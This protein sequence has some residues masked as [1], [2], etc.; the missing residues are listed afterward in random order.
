MNSVHSFSS[1]PAGAGVPPSVARIS[2]TASVRSSS[3]MSRS[4]PATP[5]AVSTSPPSSAPHSRLIASV[6]SG[7]PKWASE[8]SGIGSEAVG[9]HPNSSMYPASLAT[10]IRS[11]GRSPADISSTVTPSGASR[12]IDSSASVSRAS[13]ASVNGT[14]T[15][16]RSVARGHSRR[17]GAGTCARQSKATDSRGAAIPLKYGS[18]GASP[19][20][21]VVVF[22][23]SH[24]RPGRTSGARPG[25]SSGG[26]NTEATDRG[27]RSTVPSSPPAPV[28]SNRSST[29]AGSRPYTGQVSASAPFPPRDLEGGTWT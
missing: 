12:R 20:G 9:F 23:H 27:E 1:H 16:S 24:S 21:G 25:S 2:E 22:V 17:P 28:F 3:S 14:P 7:S 10:T 4:S 18:T 19:S 11:P 15:A 26:P 8:S 13:R 6:L 29:L 5:N